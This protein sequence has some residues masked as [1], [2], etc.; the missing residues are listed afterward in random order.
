METIEK[1]QAT[2]VQQITDLKLLEKAAALGTVTP[3]VIDYVGSGVDVWAPTPFDGLGLSL[4]DFSK[5][6]TK[7]VTVGGQTITIP[8]IVDLLQT[9]GLVSNQFSS[10]SKTET[11]NE[12]AVEAGVKVKYGLFSGGA[13]V[14]YKESNTTRNSVYYT[15]L[16]DEVSFADVLLNNLDPQ[17]FATDFVNDLDGLPA[18]VD[19]STYPLFGRFF[20]KWGIYYLNRCSLGG[21][22]NAYNAVVINDNTNTNSSK[23]DISGQYDG[24]FVSGSFSASLTTSY[25]WATYSRE[26]TTKI[27]I[28]GGT[29]AEQAAV[30]HVDPLKPSLDTVAAYQNWLGTTATTPAVNRLK[31][32][33]IA[34]LAGNKRDQV[35]KAIGMYMTNVTINL[36]RKRKPNAIY[37]W[38]GLGQIWLN[39]VHVPISD[40]T[41]PGFDVC[42]IDRKDS[43][44]VVTR[45][46]GY[47]EAN[48]QVEAPK[49]YLDLLNYLKTYDSN[50]T[51]VLC[52]QSMG[53]GACPPAEFVDYTTNVLGAGTAAKSWVQDT[54]MSGDGLRSVC[55]MLISSP[56]IGNNAGA[57]QFIDMYAY[58]PPA[59][60]FSY[61]GAATM[62]LEADYSARLIDNL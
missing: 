12:I 14:A 25:S 44:K 11:S 1:K 59:T 29:P 35:S 62:V 40:G 58:N 28:T 26:S 5:C 47:T 24:L 56:N 30:A 27:A 32:N 60:T 16:V 10:T 54:N 4:F 36:D 2:V 15:N 33:P 55:Y 39:D 43:A 41:K 18:A 19:Q 61:Q 57:S 20:A 3:A 52:A 45:F 9:P 50:Y 21:S 31:F 37:F 17:Y 49:M 22:L 13:N 6:P 46:F 51:I 8:V 53:N 23:S 34:E 42:I 48:W 7:T 38:D